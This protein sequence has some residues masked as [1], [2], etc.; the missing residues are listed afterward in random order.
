MDMLPGVYNSFIF[1]YLHFSSFQMTRNEQQFEQR[2][3][4]PKRALSKTS[5]VSL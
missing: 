4:R 2:S 3:H 1:Y 5:D